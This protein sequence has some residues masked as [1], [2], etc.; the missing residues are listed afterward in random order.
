M[1][2]RIII[3]FLLIS[4]LIFNSCGSSNYKNNKSE[5]TSSADISMSEAREE[6]YP[7]DNASIVS[8]SISATNT[9]TARKII[10]TADLKFKSKDAAKVTYIIEDIAKENGGFVE[11][12]QILKNKQDEKLVQ[13]SKDSALQIIQYVLNSNITLRVP[14][15]N[16]DT[17][18]K[19]ISAH[20]DFLESRNLSAEDA[21]LIS[22]REEL[23]QKRA[24]MSQDRIDRLQN[25]KQGNLKDNI[26]AEDARYRRQLDVDEA[27]LK[28][29][30]LDDKIKFSTVHLNIYED[31][32]EFKTTI[33]YVENLSIY[34]SNF[35]LRFIDSLK[36]GWYVLL[37]FILVL[38]S[39]WWLIAIGIAL[40]ILIRNYKR[41]NRKNK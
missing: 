19:Q 9:D 10:K 27:N 21:T 4:A 32:K 11:S 39:L 1:Q 3:F 16:L 35:G 26:S 30:E 24:T 28:K 41:H 34:K 6:A 29:M 2:K 18:L 31:K 14:Q 12:S 23:K 37:E 25:S 17:L 22:L 33:P 5:I 13:T 7:D 40:F 8:S 38:V 36:T 15:Q 20:I